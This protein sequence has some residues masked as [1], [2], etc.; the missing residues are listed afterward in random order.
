MPRIATLGIVLGTAL[1]LCGTAAH[2]QS[3]NIDFGDART[4]PAS[5]YPAAGLPGVWNVLGVPTPGTHYPLVNLAGVAT[6]V[7]LN[8]FGGTGLLLA[9]D[10]AT[11]GDHERL[12]DDML[13]GFNN[14]V[15]VCI[16]VRNLPAGTYEVLIYG[17]T[18]ADAA[19]LNR[20]RVDDANQGPIWIGGAFPGFHQLN[21]TYSRHTVNVTNGIIGLHSGEWA[22]TYQSG[23]NGIQVRRLVTGDANGDGSVNVSDL[24]LVIN[25]WGP[26]PASPP[27]N[28]DLDGNGQVNVLDLL[29][30]INHWS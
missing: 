20:T 22:A 10:P 28:A 11:S 30:V 6:G 15:D 27:C 4:A 18:P 2:G 14:P 25:G 16:W 17:I 3:Y 9:N 23:I 24:L 12:L 26:C 13:I 19:T 5:S 7:T 21:L 8:N 1:A 29:L